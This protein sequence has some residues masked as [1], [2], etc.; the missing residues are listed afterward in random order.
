LYK[1]KTWSLTL[2]E[3]RRL[4]VSVNRVLRRLF[5]P[6]RN[7]VTGGRGNCIMRSLYSTPSVIRMTKSRKMKWTE[8]LTRVEEKRNE[9]MILVGKPEKKTDH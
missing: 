1:C 6:K 5:G 4:R 7:E 2:K 3:E 9:Y 8:H